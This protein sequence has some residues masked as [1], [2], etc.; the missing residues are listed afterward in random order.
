MPKKRPKNISKTTDY[1]IDSYQGFRIGD[2]VTCRSIKSQDL[3]LAN[4]PSLVGI[5]LAIEYFD[6]P[7]IVCTRPSGSYA[8][9]LI[10]EDLEIWGKGDEP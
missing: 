9:G 8:P 5:E 7:W 3:E 10:A 4:Y 6:P 2:R 1:S